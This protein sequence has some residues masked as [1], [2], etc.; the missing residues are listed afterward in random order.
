MCLELI[1]PTRY[2]RC[3]RQ[4]DTLSSYV[5]TEGC[6]VFERTRRACAS[7]RKEYLAMSTKRQKCPRH[8]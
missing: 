4:C 3:G 2:T 5:K 7:P 8:R 6:V 1:S